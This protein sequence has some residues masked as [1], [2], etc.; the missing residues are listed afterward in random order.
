MKDKNMKTVNWNKLDVDFSDS[1]SINFGD[2][3]VDIDNFKKGSKDGYVIDNDGVKR[4]IDEVTVKIIL[5]DYKE[6]W[7]D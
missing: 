2:F 5:E 7:E 4:I 6:N 1:D 3:E